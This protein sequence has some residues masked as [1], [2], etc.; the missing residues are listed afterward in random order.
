MIYVTVFIAPFA[1]GL[2]P[3]NMWVLVPLS[4]IPL[5]LV[6]KFSQIWENFKNSSTGQLSFI[7]AFLNFLG[8]SARIFTTFVELN[9]MVILV[10]YATVCLLN[11]VIVGQ[12][13]WYW[14][15]PIDKR[16][17]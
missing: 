11:G 9:D 16:R 5:N 15:S 10:N 13:L 7:T 17:D 2:L 6:V 4:N 14:N 12:L 1:G 3:E 8:T